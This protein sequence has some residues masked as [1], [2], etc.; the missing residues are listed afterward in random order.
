MLRF[1]AN[2]GFMFPDRPHLQRIADAAKCGF[3]AVEFHGPYEV[4]AADLRAA[5]DHAK[6][7]ALCI[8]A[9]VGDTSRG[10]NGLAAVPGREA[11][12]AKAFDLSLTYA[13][14]LDIP[15]LHCVANGVNVACDEGT[16]VKNLTAFADKAAT[17]GK[18]ILIETMNWRDRPG[19]MSRTIEQAADIVGKVGRRNVK[20]LYDCY[21]LQVEGGDL[22]KRYE[23]YRDVVGHVQ[24]AAVPSRAEPD[25]GELDYP[26]I[27]KAF[28]RLGYNTGWVGAEYKPRGKTED[29]LSWVKAFE[30]AAA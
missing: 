26:E 15:F 16:Y 9:A 14:T 24:I 19:Y 17:A 18:T 7:I 4:P 1:A 3:A 21:H 13:A 5:M 10:D 30:R 6:V 11:D 28:E 23:R 2:L 25:E 20:I 27:L 12:A 22:I 8:N 29:G